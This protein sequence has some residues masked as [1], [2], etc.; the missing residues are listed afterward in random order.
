MKIYLRK[1][2][3]PYINKVINKVG[4]G[5][6]EISIDNGTKIDTLLRKKFG[7]APF[8]WEGINIDGMYHLFYIERLDK[9]GICYKNN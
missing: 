9:F 6:Q 8:G 7:N 5:W 3:N 2:L 1:M 4:G